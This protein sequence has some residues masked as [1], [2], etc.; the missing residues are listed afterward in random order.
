MTYKLPPDISTA[1]LSIY[2]CD[3]EFWP[4]LTVAEETSNTV[5]AIVS[6]DIDDDRS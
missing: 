3:G 5:K 6:E 1:G 4:W 2:T